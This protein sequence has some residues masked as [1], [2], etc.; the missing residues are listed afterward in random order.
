[1]SSNIRRLFPMY[2]S[3]SW[4]ARVM[5]LQCHL[6]SI[7]TNIFEQRGD[8]WYQLSFI[9]GRKWNLLD[10]IDWSSIAVSRDHGNRERN[11]TCL[12]EQHIHRRARDFSFCFILTLQKWLSYVRFNFKV[13]WYLCDFDIWPTTSRSHYR[14]GRNGFISHN[15]LSSFHRWSQ[16]EA[17]MCK[18]WKCLF[19][20]WPHIF[21]HNCRM[22]Y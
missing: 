2:S 18:T 17:F 16:C 22:D 7:I 6:H 21:S 8:H 10:K 9:F 12:P 4:S 15:V 3:Y 14:R 11:R 13:T 1:M 5:Y 19:G 20:S